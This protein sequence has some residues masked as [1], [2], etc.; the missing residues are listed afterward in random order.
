MIQK[1]NFSAPIPGQS[2]TGEPKQ[3]A[4]SSFSRNCFGRDY[5]K[6][7]D[8]IDW[9]DCS[10]S[11]AVASFWW[12]S[13]KIKRLAI[14]F[15]QRRCAAE[16]L[17]LLDQTL[18]LSGL[19]LVR[20]QLGNL[21]LKRHYQFEFTSTGEARHLGSITMYGLRAVNLHLDPYLLP[22]EPVD[23]H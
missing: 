3:Y 5:G 1:P 22:D 19:A 14:D 10:G 4:S 20:I 15:V 9:Y 7:V 23:F 6:R 13:D 12:Q 2:L 16:Q 21:V 17:Q 18:V 8:P 11:N